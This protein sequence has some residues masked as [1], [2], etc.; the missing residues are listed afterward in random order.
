[1]DKLNPP[2]ALHFSEENLSQAC[3]RWKGEYEFFMI[4]IESDTKAD[5]IK[6][7]IFLTCIGVKGREVY[8]TFTF[9][10]EDDKLKI[11]KIIERFDAYCEPVKNITYI[12]HNVFTCKQTEGQ[13]FD[14]YLTELKRRALDCEFGNLRED[15]IKDILICGIHEEKLRERLLQMP[16]VTLKEATEQGLA[17]KEI[18]RH[19]AEFST[20]QSIN[21]IQNQA[22]AASSNCLRT[23]K[24]FSNKVS[25]CQYCGG[26]HRRGNCP[27]Y[28]MYCSKCNRKGH[29]TSC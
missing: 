6:S 1:M 22:R 25:N 4:A 9:E 3:K 29:F 5:K 28:H 11:K 2:Q 24:S 15:L 13:R 26:S 12:R 14:E 7:S 23:E 10:S 17:A 18:K 8:S 16:K 27:A 20:S 19:F 21:A